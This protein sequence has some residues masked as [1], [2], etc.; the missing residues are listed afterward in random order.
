MIP[1][2]YF[3][4]ILCLFCVNFLLVG[5]VSY[6]HERVESGGAVEG[7]VPRPA[8]DIRHHTLQYP[9]NPTI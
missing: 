9:Q 1:N 4:T 7:H 8:V 2:V 6:L 5:Y 3:F